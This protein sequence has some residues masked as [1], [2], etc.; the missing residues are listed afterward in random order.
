MPQAQ[1]TPQQSQQQGQQGGQQQ[2]GQ[3]QGGQRPG[4]AGDVAGLDYAGGAAS[5]AP[6]PEARPSGRRIRVERG[7]TLWAISQRELGD[8][9][10]WPQL[11]AANKAVVPNKNNLSVGTVLVIPAALD[12][13]VGA[14]PG[15]ETGGAAADAGAQIT[16]GAAAR[17]GTAGA[18]GEGA[19]PLRLTPVRLTGDALA[20]AIRFYERNGSRYKSHVT[21]KIQELVGET[22]DGVLGGDTI[23]AIAAWQKAKG[24]PPDGIAGP[25]TL[26]AM[27]GRDIRND[28]MPRVAPAGDGEVLSAQAL[29]SATDWV[30]RHRSQFSPGV[31]KEIEAKLGRPVD[32]VADAELIRSIA[33]WQKA[34]GLD[35][36]GI[37]GPTTL[38]AMFGR[39]IRMGAQTQ[40]PADAQAQT[41]DAAGGG[42]SG[43]PNGLR[44]I[45]KAFGE[46]GTGIVSRA[47]RAGPGGAMINVNCHGKIADKL[48]AVFEDV[49]K[50]GMSAHIKSFDG[51]YVYRRK[52]GSSGSWSTHAWGIAVDVN[53]A[54]NPMVSKRAR[55][56]VSSDQNVL[57]PYFERHGFYWGGNFGD[58]MHFQYCRGY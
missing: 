32:G 36:D 9:G 22:Q 57:V 4:A 34:H 25:A 19:A 51:G 40:G 55:M 58:P 42:V 6:P 16:G 44:E 38:Q 1:P 35:A 26:G 13:R 14:E 53:A 7:D 3:Q 12:Q 41:A 5:V 50:D 46:P 31:I 39:D 10:K 37:P 45:K 28:P 48:A 20:A 54:W 24:L 30:K 2:G 21:R 29:W 52:R 23:R 49:F 15:D 18:T 56:K 27:F 11:W 33:T 8:G 43:V 17:E 47:M